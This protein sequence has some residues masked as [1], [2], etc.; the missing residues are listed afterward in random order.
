MSV[1]PRTQGKFETFTRMAVGTSMH[2]RLGIGGGL[3]PGAGQTV[4]RRDL[5]QF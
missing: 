2:T 3:A 4:R 5:I 1:H